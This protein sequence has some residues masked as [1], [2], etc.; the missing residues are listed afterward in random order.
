[1]PYSRYRIQ[2]YGDFSRK[3]FGFTYTR[4][5]IE[6]NLT[7]SLYYESRYSVILEI[8]GR[9]EDILKTIIKSKKED[10]IEDVHILNKSI[11]QNRLTDF[12]ML[13]QID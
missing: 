4:L 3:G 8:T 11:T 12:I 6:N 5:A 10:Y 2:L 9:D 7:G 13:N 1:M